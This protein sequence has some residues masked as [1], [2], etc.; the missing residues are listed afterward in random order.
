MSVTHAIPIALLILTILAFFAMGRGGYAS[1][2]IPQLV[3]VLLLPA[4]YGFP[5][6]IIRNEQNR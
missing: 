3:L 6:K 4:G 5:R 1:F 2:G